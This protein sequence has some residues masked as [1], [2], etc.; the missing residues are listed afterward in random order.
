M[1]FKIIKAISMFSIILIALLIQPY[2]YA[3]TFSYDGN[4]WYEIEVSIFTN[5][6]SLS[7]N[8]ELFL[9]DSVELFYPEPILELTPALANYYIELPIENF[10]NTTNNLFLAQQ[11]LSDTPETT[12]EFGPEL[13]DPN[14]DFR[15]IDKARD[16]FIALPETEHQFTRYNQNL[17]LSSDHR[18][19]F[20]AVW[21]QPVLN[22]VQ[23]SAIFVKGGDRY[24]QHNELEGSLLISYNINR[25]D[26]DARLWRNSFNVVS[27][28]DW[29]VPL[30][31]FK[32]TSDTV[33]E[34]RFNLLIDQVYPMLETRQMISNELHYLDHPALGMLIEVR[35]YELP[36]IFDFS[37][38]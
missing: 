10:D 37:L 31:P 12:P 1:K 28:P 22:K 2:T 26:V 4:R 36:A 38:D 9:P 16:P 23:A 14:D 25:V 24:G 21:R 29:N 35:P 6:S 5:Q 19:L 33:D 32:E 20:H 3:Q 15:L 8:P 13:R 30:Q 11:S 34:G 27:D 18:V 17:N 7:R